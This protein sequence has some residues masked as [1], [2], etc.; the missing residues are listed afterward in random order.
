MFTTPSPRTRQLHNL[1]A[2]AGF[3]FSGEV[4]T[5][6]LQSL[7]VLGVDFVP[8]AVAL[9]CHCHHIN[10]SINQSIDNADVKSDTPSAGRAEQDRVRNFMAPPPTSISSIKYNNGRNTTLI[11]RHP[12]R[13]IHAV[14][15]MRQRLDGCTRHRARHQRTLP[16]HIAEQPPPSANKTSHTGHNPTQE[17]ASSTRTVETTP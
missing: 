9:R 17:Y 12:S 11:S 14:Q 6:S 15:Q 3:V 2:C 4:Q 16:Q 8:V 7:D 1:H 5:R 13:T 10:Q